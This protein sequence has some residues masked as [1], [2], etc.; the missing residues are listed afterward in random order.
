MRGGVAVVR[1]ACV[2]VGEGKREK[3]IRGEEEEE[4]AGEKKTGAQRMSEEK[5]NVVGAGWRRALGRD[6][7]LYAVVAAAVACGVPSHA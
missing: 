4:K 6:E 7:G 3:K 1:C 5:E 2:R